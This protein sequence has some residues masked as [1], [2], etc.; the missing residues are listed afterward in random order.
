MIVDGAAMAVAGVV[1]FALLK[2]SGLGLLALP[3]GLYCAYVG[4]AI[5]WL[6][7]PETVTAFACVTIALIALERRPVSAGWWSSSVVWLSLI[8]AGAVLV[9]CRTELLFALAAGFAVRYRYFRLRADGVAMVG[10]AATAVLGSVVLIRHYSDARYPKG[11]AVVQLFH[12]LDALPLV[13]A[14]CFLLPALAPLIVMWR[15]REVAVSVGPVARAKL[16]LLSVI[17][18]EI[19]ATFTV[20]RIEEIRLLFPISFA[21]AWVGLDLWRALVTTLHL[22][23]APIA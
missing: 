23:D 5:A 8:A 1:G 2:R 4:T 18:T 17:V 14:A 11:T 20:G 19:L 9:G 3:A 16:P 10:L 7:K 6:P 21:L 13:V 15:H 22:E 12:N